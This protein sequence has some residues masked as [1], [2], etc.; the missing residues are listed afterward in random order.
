MAIAQKASSQQQVQH[1]LDDWYLADEKNYDAFAAK[2]Q[3]NGE[4]AAQAPSVTAMEKWSLANDIR[5]T[6]TI[7]FN[8][9]ELPPE[10]DL[11]DLPYFLQE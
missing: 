6:P 9:Y 10:Y 5:Y 7:F 4:V 2:Y 8:G 11:E 1:A 3:L